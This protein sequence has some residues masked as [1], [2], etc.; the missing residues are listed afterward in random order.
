MLWPAAASH[1]LKS[2]PQ[3]AARD[4]PQMAKEMIANVTDGNQVRMDGM[5]GPPVKH[6]VG[7]PA[8]SVSRLAVDRRLPLD[9][10]YRHSAVQF[11][12]SHARISA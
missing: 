10:I 2:P 6:R 11:R 8:G 7:T 5:I 4:G 12:A 1:A 9:L 3:G